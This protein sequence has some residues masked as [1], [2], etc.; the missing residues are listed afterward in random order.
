[1]GLTQECIESK[2]KKEEYIKIGRK[3]TVGCF[4]LENGFEIVTSSACVKE[5][6]YDEEIGKEICRKQAINKI[7]ELEGYLIQEHFYLYK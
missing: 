3:T 7:W 2:I 1:M 5:E 6:D 4:T